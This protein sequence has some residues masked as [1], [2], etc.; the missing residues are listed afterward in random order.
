[1]KKNR[2][3]IITQIWKS[4]E[5]RK[6]ILFSLGILV[7]FRVLASIPVVGIPSNAIKDLFAGNGFGDILSTVSGGVLETATVVAIGLGPYIN[8]S[9]ILQL[10][11]SVIPK[12]EQLRKE[13]TQG[14]KVIS[15]WTRLLSV[16]LAFLQSFVIYS[17]LRAVNPPLMPELDP[18]SFFAMSMTLT[19]GAVLMMWFGELISEKGL[20]QGSSYIIF[21][22]IVAS[23]P[24][25]FRDNV[26]TMDLVELI[27]FVAVYLIIIASVVLIS[28]GERRIKVQYSRRV[29]TG[30][31]YESFIPIKLTQFGVMPVIFA[32]SLFTFPQ[33]IAQF[34]VS[35]NINE[36]VNYYSEKVI[37]ILSNPWIYNI[38]L[39]ALVVGFCFFYVTIVFNTDELSENLQKQGAFIPGVRPGKTTSQ[40]LKRASFKLT[41]VGAPF[42]GLLTILP[43]ILQLAGVINYELMSGTGFL[44]AVGT[45]LAIRN[46]VKS[47]TV[48]RGYD[49]YL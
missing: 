44:I 11:G 41:A 35:R 45:L 27:V 43:G 17:S 14:R 32:I 38:G 34:L 20:G 24:G 25:L 37:E 5:I 15:M 31:T 29:R 36:Q 39:F 3:E 16:P 12:L 18:L 47:M 10:L 48:V 28:E 33:L 46:Q 13:G 2:F 22:G 8:A 40:Y 26:V 1:M 30:A 6:K 7:V 9:I 42:L 21:L 23:I 4:Q 19:A 49:K